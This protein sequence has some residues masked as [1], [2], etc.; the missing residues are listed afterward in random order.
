VS[1]EGGFDVGFGGVEVAVE[2]GFG[3]D[4]PAGGAEAAVGGDAEVAYGL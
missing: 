2:E 4:D 3:G 1:G